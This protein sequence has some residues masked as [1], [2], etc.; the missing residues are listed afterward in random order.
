MFG[1]QKTKRQQMTKYIR[2]F[3]RT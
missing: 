1:Y 2:S 3:S